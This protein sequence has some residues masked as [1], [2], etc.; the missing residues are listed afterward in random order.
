MLV[1]GITGS[2]KTTYATELARR[3]GLPFHSMDALFHGPGWEPIPTFVDDVGAIVDGDAWVF[4]SHGHSEVQD[5]MWARADTAIWLAYPRVVAA[6]RV[7]RRCRAGC[8]RN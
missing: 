3:L 6:T 7:T 5:L 2:G 1:A 4:D 8:S